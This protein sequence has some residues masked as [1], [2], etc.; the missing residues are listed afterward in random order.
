MSLLI[1]IMDQNTDLGPP[2]QPQREGIPRIKNQTTR[3]I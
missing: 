1:L 2:N 3:T